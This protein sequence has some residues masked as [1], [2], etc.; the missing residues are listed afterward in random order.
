MS[1]NKPNIGYATNHNKKQVKMKDKINPI[2]QHG[3]KQM[4]PV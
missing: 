4:F 3:I 1:S 2:S